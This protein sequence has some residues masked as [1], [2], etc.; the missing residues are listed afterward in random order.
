MKHLETNE[1]E[2]RRRRRRIGRGTSYD[3]FGDLRQ[4]AEGRRKREAA[5]I[6]ASLAG[7]GVLVALL[8]KVLSN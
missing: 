4:E 6:L 8:A 1:V 3:R 2:G 7:V 5:M